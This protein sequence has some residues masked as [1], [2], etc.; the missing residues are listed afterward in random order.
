MA[1]VSRERIGRPVMALTDGGGYGEYVVTH[2]ARVRLPEQASTPRCRVS[3][4]PVHDLAG[5]LYI[6]GILT[7]ER[8]CSSMVVP[9]AWV[10][11][12]PGWPSSSILCALTPLLATITGA[13][14]PDARRNP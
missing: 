2:S 10:T 13:L 14:V 8:A 12:F 4:S 11:S 7:L 3:P 1:N 9:A 5:F 6:D